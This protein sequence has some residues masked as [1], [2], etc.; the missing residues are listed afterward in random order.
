MIAKPKKKTPV[1]R[2]ADK[3]EPIYRSEKKG[4]RAADQLI[5]GRTLIRVAQPPVEIKE[6]DLLGGGAGG[7]ACGG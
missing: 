2:P 3:K 5:G 6:I 1:E 4:T 7:S